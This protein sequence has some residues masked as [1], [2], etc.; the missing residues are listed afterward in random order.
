MR[1][2]TVPK[3]IASRYGSGARGFRA[4]KR[5]QMRA[6]E[7]AYKELRNGSAYF[8]SGIPQMT[9]LES[10]IESVKQ[11]ISRKNWGN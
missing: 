7:K 6:L 5:R 9:A 4:E 10:A 3:F 8:P 2:R 11:D 1:Q